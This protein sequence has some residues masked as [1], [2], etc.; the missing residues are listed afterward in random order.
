MID[1]ACDSLLSNH[2]STPTFPV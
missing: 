1:W 2:E